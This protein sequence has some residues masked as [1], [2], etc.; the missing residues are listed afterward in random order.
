[1]KL[2]VDEIILQITQSMSRIPFARREKVVEKLE[3]L[4]SL[5]Y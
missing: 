4:N 2:Y 5:M 3:N 1:M